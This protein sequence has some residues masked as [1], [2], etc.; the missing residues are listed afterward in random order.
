MAFRAKTASSVPRWKNIV[1]PSVSLITVLVWMLAITWGSGYANPRWRD[2]LMTGHISRDVVFHAAYTEM[3]ATYGRASTGLDGLPYVPYHF[4]SHLL[5]AALVKLTNTSALTIYNLVFPWLLPVLY[6]AAF[7]MFVMALRPRTDWRTSVP[8][9]IVIV[10]GTIRV[11]PQ[12]I[13]ES[14]GMW[15]L[16][17]VSESAVLGQA[18]FFFGAAGIAR[19]W[20]D[21]SWF[22]RLI[23]LPALCFM[24][25]FSKQS[26][27]FVAVGGLA[28]LL[29]TENRWRQRRYWPCAAL[30]LVTACLNYWLTSGTFE[31][32]HIVPFHFVNTWTKTT[33]PVWLLLNFGWA[34]LYIGL[35]VYER[36]R[37]FTDVYVL[38]A[39]IATG[40][41]P[42]ML[43]EIPGGSAGY[44]VEIQRY[45]DC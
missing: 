20:V 32:V 9:W 12:P 2:L 45:R 15:S 39:L 1:L 31:T 23:G 3:L 19:G 42:A 30:V 13:A 6:T 14:Y 37:P 18:I 25:G 5:A 28:A 40:L 8:F 44:F 41:I 17:F 33:V 36:R 22:F 7:M 26:L 27:L 16:M 38:M 29:F 4:G 35:R 43:L 21:R 10:S 11:L 34:W 24:L